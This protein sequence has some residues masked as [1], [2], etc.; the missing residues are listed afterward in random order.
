MRKYS[1]IGDRILKAFIV[2][3]LCVIVVVMLA[4]ILNV[5]S[6]SLSNS[7][8]VEA[9]KVLLWPVN[10]TL[11]SWKHVLS[12]SEI[13]R[14]LGLNILI[15]V[16]GTFLAIMINA[17]MAYPLSKKEFKLGTALIFLV[18]VTMIFKAPT[19]PYYIVLRSYGLVDNFWVLI[20]P[21]LI[22]S[23]YLLIMI[24]F[25][26][27]FPSE[28]EE[29]A[30]IDG[31][32]YFKLWSRIVL[33]CSKPVISTLIMFYAATIWNQFTHPKM[34]INNPNMF[35]LQLKVRQIIMESDILDF[36]GG[37]TGALPYNSQTLSAVTVIFTLLPIACVYP[38]VQKNFIKGAMIGSVK[39]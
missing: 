18:V 35:P 17:L 9:G 2:F 12:S 4:P 19:I 23:Y 37:G 39:G 22:L 7:R 10:I 28:I 8:A 34:F 6:M 31:C 24:S 27:D 16:V 32:G 15:T 3:L 14:A 38:L 20:L 26:R 1:G 13:W 29:A 33:P 25:F 21:H 5:L 30:V 36:F 11:S